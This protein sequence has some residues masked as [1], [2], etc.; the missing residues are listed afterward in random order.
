MAVG[1]GS[2]VNTNNNNS[3]QPSGNPVGNNLSIGSSVGLWKFV[4]DTPQPVIDN[5]SSYDKLV[6]EQAMSAVQDTSLLSNF[7]GGIVSTGQQVGNYLSDA[8]DTGAEAY[9]RI[10]NV[11]KS[12]KSSWESILRWA[13]S[14]KSISDIGSSIAPTLSYWASQ[15]LKAVK[16]WT[17]FGLDVGAAWVASYVGRWGIPVMSTIQSLAPEVSQK[18][19]DAFT[20]LQEKSNDVNKKE[21]GSFLTPTAS[22][23][24]SDILINALA[25]WGMRW[26]AYVTSKLR[27]PDVAPST[28][29]EALSK[30]PTVENGPIASE[31]KPKP[32]PEDSV[33]NF[34]SEIQQK[35]IDGGRPLSKNEVINISE[36]H[37]GSDVSKSIQPSANL[38]RADVLSEPTQKHDL[39]AV[40]E[41]FV[42]DRYNLST[43]TKRAVEVALNEFWITK[44]EAR[45]MIN[46]RL[47]N[48]KNIT[49]ESTAVGDAIRDN[50][51]VVYWA[52]IL[53]K[54]GSTLK[55]DTPDSMVKG[56]SLRHLEE[57]G[58]VEKKYE[59][60][61]TLYSFQL[62]EK[63]RKFLS[64]DELSA[65]DTAGWLA[66][67]PASSYDWI[68][69]KK[70][71]S[72]PIEETNKV[73]EKAVENIDNLP[74]TL[75]KI[76]Q[77][78]W[79]SSLIKEASTPSS[80]KLYKA[81]KD[82]IDNISM[83]REPSSSLKANIT[84]LWDKMGIETSNI[85]DYNWEIDRA[86]LPSVMDQFKAAEKFGWVK[87][88]KITLPKSLKTMLK[89]DVQ[90]ANAAVKLWLK[91]ERQS[92]AELRKQVT[93]VFNSIADGTSDYKYYGSKKEL[94]SLKIETRDKTANAKTQKEYDDI[95]SNLSETLIKENKKY[96]YS[97]IRKELKDFRRA[98]R[99]TTE[100]K[101]KISNEYL[102]QLEAI[103]YWVEEFKRVGD[104]EVLKTA[105]D[106]IKYMKEEGYKWWIIK[107]RLDTKNIN[108]KVK[109]IQDAGLS[110]IVPESEI[111]WKQIEDSYTAFSKKTLYDFLDPHKAIQNM[112]GWDISHPLYKQV[113]EL[114]S[115]KAGLEKERI[116]MDKYLQSFIK[117]YE[118]KANPEFFNDFNNFMVLKRG[119]INKWLYKDWEFIG[120]RFFKDI[121][122]TTEKDFLEWKDGLNS[123]MD[124]P[125]GKEI[126]SYYRSFIDK[127]YGIN[128]IVSAKYTGRNAPHVDNYWPMMLDKLE[129][130]TTFE[131][132]M[133]QMDW[134]M[135]KWFFEQAKW[136]TRSMKGDFVSNINM[137][138]GTQVKYAYL[139]PPVTNLTRIIEAGWLHWLNEYSK[140]VITDLI[141]DTI[142]PTVMPA[143]WFVTLVWRLGVQKL[144]LN[145]SPI[146]QQF[147][148]LADGL[149]YMSPDEISQWMKMVW[150]PDLIDKAMMA[151]PELELA[152][153]AVDPTFHDIL[154]NNVFDGSEFTTKW[155]IKASFAK[156]NAWIKLIEKYGTQW[157]RWADSSTK[158]QIWMGLYLKKAIENWDNV[159]WNTIKEFDNV[160]AVRYANERVQNIA[161]WRD[162]TR[163]PKATKNALAKAFFS[164]QSAQLNRFGT[165]MNELPRQWKWDKRQFAWTVTGAVLSTAYQTAVSIGIPTLYW[166]LGIKAA[167]SFIEAFT[168]KSNPNTEDW[169]KAFALMIAKQAP[170]MSNIIS[171]TQFWGSGIMLF[172]SVTKSVN[173]IGSII[174]NARIWNNLKM[175]QATVDL[176]AQ[177]ILTHPLNI[178]NGKLKNK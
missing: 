19:S 95:L 134:T 126:S 102:K 52:S 83:G 123:R 142:V 127:I 87:P 156:A 55:F 171:T 139:Y 148:T 96:L 93:E 74:E 69:L 18:L 121:E 20:Y 170:G 17:S 75:N 27:K 164:L 97:E 130:V 149:I 12:L 42:W 124:N 82:D 141:K 66:H 113:S 21:L 29:E 90:V 174:K 46:E 81:I 71:K 80:E 76:E 109:D 64:K 146:L 54:E 104:V 53:G 40:L 145:P 128:D 47:R 108:A 116:D 57:N 48:N 49:K 163:M 58:I 131:Q 101:K 23:A 175:E 63:G 26:T 106:T 117:K 172:D 176:I 39:N 107:D 165:Y 143:Q 150:R 25:E 77:S 155:V 11:K 173:D 62:T 24:V 177:W 45:D 166:V 112:V 138:F 161:G 154:T 129:S 51:S 153:G 125:M 41:Q 22:N 168:W 37:L 10:Q 60:G 103:A 7:V 13:L 136:G 159:R 2:F 162:V 122:F 98:E 35:A 68:T 147:G 28:I 119:D 152:R 86:R 6:E 144:V 8:L 135:N 114:D 89:R 157:L 158:T 120:N 137:F 70:S 85:W 160:D 43:N 33:K 50:L 34:L 78:K 36:S 169:T 16:S 44:K 14:G 99:P 61:D 59:K 118:G 67:Y 65:I 72:S 133:A 84:R 132:A 178:I 167:K 4:K 91:T 79:D 110:S 92:R 73:L 115:G 9:G 15:G 56:E 111:N 105:L 100:N 31:I 3:N 140:G 38:D 32:S 1:L 94:E 30:E 88:T 5:R 151:S